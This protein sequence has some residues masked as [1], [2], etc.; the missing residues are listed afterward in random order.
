MYY[1]FSKVTL[2]LVITKFYGSSPALPVYILHD[3]TE[4]FVPD[5]SINMLCHHTFRW[6]EPPTPECCHI[7][8]KN[9]SILRSLPI[10]LLPS[11]DLENHYVWVINAIDPLVV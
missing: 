1:L 11:G 9:T 4:G 5:I 2:S 10:F 3:L 6:V 8:I 7:V